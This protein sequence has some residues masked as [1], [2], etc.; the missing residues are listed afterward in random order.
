MVTYD[1]TRQGIE[2]REKL[3]LTN[4][5]ILNRKRKKPTRTFSGSIIPGIH[6]LHHMGAL[7]ESH[8]LLDLQKK[9]QEPSSFLT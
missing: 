9:L 1:L 5:Y 2:P 4:V 8:V 7:S 6:K 3:L